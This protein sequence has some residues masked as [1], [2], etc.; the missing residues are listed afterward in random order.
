MEKFYAQIEPYSFGS[1]FRP[2][3]H[4]MAVA[5][6]A[7]HQQWK[8]DAS[9]S[10]TFMTRLP[11]D[12]ALRQLSALIQSAQSEKKW[13]NAFVRLSSRSPKDA[14]LTSPKFHQLLTQVWHYL[15]AIRACVARVSRDGV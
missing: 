5:L 9:S 4:D 15:S 7:A 3:T 14:A 11:A 12:H 10:A 1:T 8:A 13:P 2:L 6:M